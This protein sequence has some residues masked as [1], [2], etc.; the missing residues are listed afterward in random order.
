MG[1]G[2][3]L[4]L[5]LAERIGREGDC[6][7][8]VVGGLWSMLSFGKMK[9]GRNQRWGGWHSFISSYC[10]VSGHSMLYV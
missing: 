7:R 9:A 3:V 6:V 1:V 4:A 5:V 10:D 2:V 8:W